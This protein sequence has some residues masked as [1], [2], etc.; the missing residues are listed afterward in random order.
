MF[1]TILS[2][3]VPKFRIL[4]DPSFGRSFSNLIWH[5]FELALLVL[6]AGAWWV[7]ERLA[8]VVS[9]CSVGWALP[10]FP[11]LLVG[12]LSRKD[13]AELTC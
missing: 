3:F 12:L 6:D 1:A 8:C 11:L 2:S 10:I 5:G 4:L 13:L 7:T 9:S